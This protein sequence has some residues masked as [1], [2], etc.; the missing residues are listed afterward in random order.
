MSIALAVIFDMDGVIV[1]SEPLHERAFYA[2]MD[3]LGYGHN[4]GIRVADFI[5]RSDTELWLE[6]IAKHRPAQP[7]KELLALKRKLVIGLL[8]DEEIFAG[9][10]ELIENVAR[11][12]RIA[13]ASGSERPFIDAVLALKDLRHFFP[14][15]ADAGEVA[16]GKPA[17]DIFLLA[18][19]RLGV[20][21]EECWVIEDSKPGITAGLA[22]GMRVIAVT[23]THPAAELHHAT[24]VARNYEEIAQL[25]ASEQ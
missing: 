1:N 25:L 3:Q 13:L 5:G 12:Y 15:I 20:E 7:I 23:N 2:L 22:A 19:R 21:P 4:H 17:P 14:V 6:F 11:R 9:L 18:A 24:H 16:K 8:R 10:P